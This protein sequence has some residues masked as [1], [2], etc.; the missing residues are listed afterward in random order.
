[1]GRA[2]AAS[3]PTARPSA[4]RPGGPPRQLAVGWARTSAGGREGCCGL[5]AAVM[6]AT[7]VTTNAVAIVVFWY[8]VTLVFNWT[9][10]NLVV[11]KDDPALALLPTDITLIEM[12][13][14]TVCGALTLYTKDLDFIPPPELRFRML[15]LA[16]ANAAAC[17]LFMFAMDF[18]ALSLVQTIRACQPIFTVLVGEMRLVPY[19]PCWSCSAASWLQT[20]PFLHSA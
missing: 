4:L 11:L 16:V 18:V 5:G 12:A 3:R 14:C 10:F 17:Q 15:A 13:A 7:G 6:G 2:S 9:A 1:M 19:L 20:F 8:C